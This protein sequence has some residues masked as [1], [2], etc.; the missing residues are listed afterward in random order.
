[1]LSNGVLL[2]S[3]DSRDT[4]S[5]K[6]SVHADFRMARD[7]L[8]GLARPLGCGLR[9]VR[10]QGHG[11]RLT[12]PLG[13]GDRWGLGVYIPFPFVPNGYLPLLPHFSMS[14]TE[15]E[16]FL[17]PSI[18]DLKPSSKSIDFLINPWGKRVP[19]SIREQLHWFSNS[20]EHLVHVLASGCVCYSWSLAPSRLKHR[21]LN[22]PTCVVAPEGL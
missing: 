11:L 13:C 5:K 9:L 12:R 7:V 8:K 3:I 17:S 1:M 10:P 2:S 18:V 22:L 15:H 20:K 19:N 16:L 4:Q 21:P 6:V 14:K